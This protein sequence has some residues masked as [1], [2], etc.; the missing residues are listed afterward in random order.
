MKLTDT[1]IKRIKPNAKPFKVSDGGGLFF[2][3][4]LP[5]RCCP[6]PAV[7]FAA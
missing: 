2:G 4:R 6:A 3:S 1:Q 7:R 5:A